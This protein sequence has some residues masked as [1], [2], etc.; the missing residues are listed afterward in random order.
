MFLED[1]WEI[2]GSKVCLATALGQE[3]RVI[4]PPDLD[5]AP[6]R[7]VGLRFDRGRLHFFDQAS[8][9]RVG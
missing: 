1:R 2:G 4:T 6:E 9:R 3:V 8:G 7:V 5:V